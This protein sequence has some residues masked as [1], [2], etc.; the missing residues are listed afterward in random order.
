MCFEKIFFDDSGK[1]W[2]KAC[3][4]GIQADIHLFQFDGYNFKLQEGALGKLDLS[5]IIYDIHKGKYIVGYS[6]WPNS[7][8]AFRYHLHEDQLDTVEIHTD[9]EVKHLIVNDHDET[10]LLSKSNN[11]YRIYQYGE[12]NTLT[13]EKEIQN[14]DAISW[15]FLHFDKRFIW[16]LARESGFLERIDW[17]TGKRQSVSLKN[18]FG[19][20]KD[21]LPFLKFLFKQNGKH[22]YFV[23]SNYKSEEK[24]KVF[25]VGNEVLTLSSIDFDLPPFSHFITSSDEEGNIVSIFSKSTFE[26]YAILEKSDGKVFD[27]SALFKK[28]QGDRIDYISS[29]DFTKELYGCSERGLFVDKVKFNNHIKGFLNNS[30]IR[31]FVEIEKNLLLVATQDEDRYFFNMETSSI[32]PA[33]PIFNNYD[34]YKIFIDEENNLWF[35]RVGAFI[36]YNKELNTTDK[37][38]IDSLSA[39]IFVLS[40]NEKIYFKSAELDLYVLDLSSKKVTPFLINGKHYRFTGFVHDLLYDDDGFIWVATNEGFF[41]IDVNNNSVEDLSSKYPQLSKRNLSIYQED[42]GKIWLGTVLKGVQI[43]DPETKEITTINNVNGLP[44]NTIASITEDREGFKWVSTYNGLSL[45]SKNGE[46]ISNFYEEDGIINN[47]FNRYSN[48]LTQSGKIILGTVKGFNVIDPSKIRNDIHKKS[49]LKIFASS[50]SYY[51]SAEEKQQIFNSLNKENI[52]LPSSKREITIEVALSNYFKSTENKFAY[53]FNEENQDW[54]DIGHQPVIHLTNIEPG[55][56]ELLIKG[57]DGK[58]NWTKQPISINIEVQQYFYKTLKFYLLLILGLASLSLIWITRLRSMI[59]K[60]TAEIR[61]DKAIIEKQANKLKDLND[62]KSRFFTNISHEFRTPL[63][64]ISGMVEQ[65]KLQPEI[66]LEK[67][68]E[69]IKQNTLNLLDLVN[70]ILD[71]RKLESNSLQLNLVQGDIISYLKYIS[72]SYQSLALK[73][74]IQLHFLS[75]K[76]KIIMD[77]DSDK[78][79]RIVS[80]LLSNAI[81]FTS[82]GG[83]IYFQIDQKKENEINYLELKFRDTGSGISQDQLSLIFDRFYQVDDSI[84]REGEGTGIGLA[85]TKELVKLMSG[86]IIVESI[87]SK[88]TTFTVSIPIYNNSEKIAAF[89]SDLNLAYEIPK[90]ISETE[91]IHKKAKSENS[92]QLPNL[93]I[94]EDNPDLVQYLV[95]TLETDYNL[96]IARNGQEGIQMALEIVP[97]LVVSD[98]MMPIKDGYQLCETLKQ[99]SLTSH[100]PIILLTAKADIDSKV[101]GLEKGADAYLSKPFEKRELLVRLKKLLELRQKLQD[102]FLSIDATTEVINKEDAFIQKVRTV[103]EENI[104]DDAFGIPQIC[105]AV[106]LQRA[107]LHNKIKALTGQSTSIYVRIIRLKRGKHLLSTTDLNV[108]E[109]AYEVGFKDPKYFSRLYIETFKELPSEVKK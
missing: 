25:I 61:E 42:N 41:K 40:N 7:H 48:I 79:L 85:L 17:Q 77:Y 15:E 64:I 71:L 76:P 11:D 97:D 104:N 57:S 99:N 9:E 103:I 22:S 81:K 38:L 105:R 49:D 24:S 70:Q 98:I 27:C 55:D 6:N 52:V 30:S 35:S 93:L 58:G 101:E 86:E 36:K 50:I 19:N 12:D 51:K 100:I 53:K 108:S 87:L 65:V 47:E 96:L 3:G 92:A 2:L 62:A 73:K 4:S 84:T 60:A 39:N 56:H 46:V 75:E 91:I 18:K 29:E 37:Y 106:G 16:R 109:V 26:H 43:F 72:E 13:I 78:I 88:G 8:Y 74:D 69:M 68:T 44:N 59:R 94:V 33:P 89:S 21:A 82:A 90:E 28:N 107:Q 14:N 54:V 67:G 80:N 1:M 23:I 32:S 20:Y 83:N 102:H 63:T 95:S 31:S 10:L 34:P 45:L 66:W 5:S